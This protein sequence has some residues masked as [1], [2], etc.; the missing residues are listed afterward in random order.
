LIA[1]QTWHV[2]V[3]WVLAARRAADLGALRYRL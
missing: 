3:G 2:Y 1:G